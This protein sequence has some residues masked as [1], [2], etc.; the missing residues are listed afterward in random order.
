MES[1]VRG[2]GAITVTKTET[3]FRVVD[4]SKVPLK[5]LVV[6][7]AAIKRDIK[8]GLTQIDGLELYEEKTTQLRTR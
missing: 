3:R 8:L 6:D 2:D 7:E 5:Y 4:L 1:I